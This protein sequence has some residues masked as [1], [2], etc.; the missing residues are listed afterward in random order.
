MKRNKG[1]FPVSDESELYSFVP[2]FYRTTCRGS[3]KR[4]GKP[5]VIQKTDYILIFPLIPITADVRFDLVNQT[6]PKVYIVKAL[7]VI[8]YKKIS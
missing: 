2:S 7:L 1:K 6:V 8:I 4:E 3:G 5:S